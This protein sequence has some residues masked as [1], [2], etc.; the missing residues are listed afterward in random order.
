MHGQD[1]QTASGEW[2][3]HILPELAGSVRGERPRHPCVY[4]EYRKGQ[5][6]DRE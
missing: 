2:E 5:E 6:Q 4:P 3:H 1:Q